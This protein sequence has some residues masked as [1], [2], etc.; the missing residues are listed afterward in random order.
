MLRI[1]IVLPLEEV[2]AVAPGIAPT[3]LAIIVSTVNASKGMNSADPFNLLFIFPYFGL[4]QLSL[5]FSSDV[6]LHPPSV[7]T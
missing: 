1:E 2:M 3:A 6:I 5:P 4:P 7:N